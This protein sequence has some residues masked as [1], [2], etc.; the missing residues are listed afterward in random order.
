LALT[1]INYHD[2]SHRAKQSAQHEEVIQ[3][4]Q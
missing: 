3:L 2:Q 4:R 1:A